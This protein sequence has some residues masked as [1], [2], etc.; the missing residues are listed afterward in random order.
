MFSNAFSAEGPVSAE[1]LMGER[2][3]PPGTTTMI[4]V[5]IYLADIDAVDDARFVLFDLPGP[6]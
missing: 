1:R 2:P 5:G 4:N 3:D 6:A